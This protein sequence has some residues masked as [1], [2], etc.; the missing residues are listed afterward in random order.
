MKLAIVATLLATASAFS[1]N[2]EVAKVCQIKMFP[3]EIHMFFGEGSWAARSFGMPVSF[4]LVRAS[5]EKGKDR[6]RIS[7]ILKSPSMVVMIDSI[8]GHCRN[9]AQPTV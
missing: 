6:N 8:A 3:F 4:S 7:M 1:V 5:V 2:K 9:K